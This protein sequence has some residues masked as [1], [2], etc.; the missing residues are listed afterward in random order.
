MPKT[1]LSISRD[2]ILLETREAILRRSGHHVISVSELSDFAKSIEEGDI[3][4]VVLGHPLSSDDRDAAYR[5]L[6][7]LDCDCP[8]IEL[9]ATSVPPKSPAHFHLQVHDRTFQS[10][11][12]QLTRQILSGETN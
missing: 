5:V 3:D 4:L 6:R 1:I 9:Y 10:D 11:L 2:H 12:L 8:V 7:E